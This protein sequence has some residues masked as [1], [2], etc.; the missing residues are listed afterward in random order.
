MVSYSF[1]ILGAWD[2]AWSYRW[3]PQLYAS[4][5]YVVLMINPEGST[6]YGQKYTDAVRQDWGGKPFQTLMNGLDQ[7]VA[8]YQYIDKNRMCSLGASYGGYMQ[9]WINAQTSDQKKF[10]CIVNH[11]G[12]FDAVAMAYST[13]E[14]W[15]TQAE[16]GGLPYNPTDYPKFEKFN[17]SNFVD[18]MTTPMLIIHGGKDFRIP[19]SEGISAF[20]A[21]QRRGI[22][23]KFLYFEMEN[24]WVLKPDNSIKWYDTVLAWLDKFTQNTPRK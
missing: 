22:E 20:T 8:Q 17:P 21:L 19:E 5:G 1:F 3:N 4:H 10:K 6:G 15:F 7:V 11:D 14:L 23:S 18:K 12:V 2:D 16:F 13:E 24:H 9:N